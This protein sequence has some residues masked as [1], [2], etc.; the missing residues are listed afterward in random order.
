MF[1]YNADHTESGVPVHV[2]YVRRVALTSALAADDAHIPSDVKLLP[3]PTPQNDR[4][5]REQFL[6]LL[7]N[8]QTRIYTQSIGIP[9]HP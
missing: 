1:K 6:A 5:S 8:Q 9:H 7:H 4:V 2:V 3:N